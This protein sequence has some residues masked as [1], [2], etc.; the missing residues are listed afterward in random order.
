MEGTTGLVASL[1]Y[2]TGRL[3]DLL[4]EIIKY[5]LSIKRLKPP[6]LAG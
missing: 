2:E 5:L 3:I 1:L 4:I 6:A